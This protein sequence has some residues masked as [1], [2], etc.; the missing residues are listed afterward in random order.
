MIEGSVRRVIEIQITI[1]WP[2]K[3][4]TPPFLPRFCRL[5]VGK[6]KSRAQSGTSG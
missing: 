6:G 5:I 1:V 4:L 2:P 3:P